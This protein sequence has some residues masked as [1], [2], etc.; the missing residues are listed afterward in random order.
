MHST[1]YSLFFQRPPTP[2]TKGFSKLK[3][4]SS[5]HIERLLRAEG[6]FWDE[7]RSKEIKPE[8]RRGNPTKAKVHLAG[9][10]LYLPTWV[11]IRV[12]LSAPCSFPGS[13]LLQLDHWQELHLLDLLG[14]FLKILCCCWEVVET[15]GGEPSGS[16]IT[17]SI[18]LKRMLGLQSLPPSLTFPSDHQKGSRRKYAEMFSSLPNIKEEKSND[19]A[20]SPNIVLPSPE[21]LGNSRH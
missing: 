15:L 10:P 1:K 5:S 8:I 6:S 13:S 20:V 11:I 21:M 16:Y 3:C 4:P 19:S 7:V 14:S 9:L 17:G 18:C 12:L 2:F